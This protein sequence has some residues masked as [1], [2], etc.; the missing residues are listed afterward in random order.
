MAT[1]GMLYRLYVLVLASSQVL[2][3][4]LKQAHDTSTRWVVTLVPKVLANVF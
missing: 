2:V 3:T 1:T 4:K